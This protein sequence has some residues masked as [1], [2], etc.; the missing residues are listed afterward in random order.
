M[1]INGAIK[2][3][4]TQTVVAPSGDRLPYELFGGKTDPFLSAFATIHVIFTF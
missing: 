2:C 3:L 1:S 4:Q